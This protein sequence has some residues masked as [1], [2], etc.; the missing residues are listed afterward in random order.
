MNKDEIIAR[1]YIVKYDTGFAPNPKGEFIT[2]ACCKPKI[3]KFAKKGSWVIGLKSR[4]KSNNPKQENRLIYAM[5][6]KENPT[7]DEYY[8]DKRFEY[9]KFY[10]D[11]DGDNIYHTDDH[12]KFKQN[13]NDHHDETDKEND[14]RGERVLI[15]DYATSYYFG[16]KNAVLIPNRFEKMLPLIHSRMH[17]NIVDDEEKK[18]FSDFLDWLE[19]EYKSGNYSETVKMKKCQLC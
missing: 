16:T 19:K 10:L 14:R 9:K 17:K 11:P 12:G 6:V 15:S 4:S 2:L 8:K 1:V 5:K 7:F 3:R 13:Y 18:L